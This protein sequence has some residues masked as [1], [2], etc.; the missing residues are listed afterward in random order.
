MASKLRTSLWILW[1]VTRTKGGGRRELGVG[2]WQ[3]TDRLQVGL[4]TGCPVM[5]AMKI[6]ARKL[7]EN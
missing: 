1:T 4:G 2:S 6:P 7:Y 3:V 5:R